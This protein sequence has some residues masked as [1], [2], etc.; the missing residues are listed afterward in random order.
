LFA[1]KKRAR[2]KAAPKLAASTV[3]VFY[4]SEV[5][6]ESSTK[7]QVRNEM[8]DGALNG[9]PIA[10]MQLLQILGVVSFV[11]LSSL[12]IL[13]GLKV[14]V[15][16]KVSANIQATLKR[17]GFNVVITGTGLI[18]GYLAIVAFEFSGIY[19]LAWLMRH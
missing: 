9:S 16:G 13:W 17:C 18:G 4:W 7:G 1:I 12:V 15:G 10:G 19:L 3:V 14:A 5:Q 2:P 6:W 8:I 11:F